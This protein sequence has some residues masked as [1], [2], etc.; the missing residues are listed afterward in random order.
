MPASRRL[1]VAAI[2]LALSPV[3]ALS[4]ALPAAAQPVSWL[5]RCNHELAS[6]SLPESG[7]YLY[8]TGGKVAQPAR[9][10]FDYTASVSARAS[11][12]P[13]ATK[14][15]LNLYS[16]PNIG[17]SYY[18]SVG[19]A[20]PYASKPTIGRISF[21]Y[22]A[23]DF[24]PILGGPI[25]LKLIVDGVAFGPFQ[26]DASSTN[27]G[28]Y[29]MWLDTAETDGDGKPPILTPTEFAKIA[30]AVETTSTVQLVLVQDKTDIA[31]TAIP[32]PNLA[33]W[34]DGFAGWAAKTKPGVGA[35][36]SCTAGGSISN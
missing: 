3:L 36:T 30:K 13:T 12:Y 23:K 25:S 22:Q 20:A 1:D 18:T 16:S 33:A 7:K 21:A 17:L 5:T 26:P 8:E 9:G 28:R 34:R 35:A 29:G 19:E 32:F 27:S 15:V 14:D 2:V 6:A 4:Q 11:T 24:K 10:V 31:S